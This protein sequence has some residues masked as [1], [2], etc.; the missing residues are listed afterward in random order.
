MFYVYVLYS[1]K[2]HG[3]YIGFT[4]DLKRRL[5]EHDGG[6]SFSTHFRRP[7]VLAYFEAYTV[8]KDAE[9]REKFLKSGS[10]RIYLKKQLTHFFAQYPLRSTA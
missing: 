10:G 2:D 6:L 5:A 8:K 3:L 7:F 4:C 9:G 1:E